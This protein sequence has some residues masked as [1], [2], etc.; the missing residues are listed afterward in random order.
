DGR[1]QKNASSHADLANQVPLE[2]APPSKLFPS[3][4]DETEHRER[5]SRDRDVQN[6]KRPELETSTEQPRPAVDRHP[7]SFECKP[8]QGRDGGSGQDRHHGEGD[9]GLD[10]YAQR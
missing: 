9:G 10:G 6:V 1:D 5:G 3:G 2:E 4:R 7:G 8:S